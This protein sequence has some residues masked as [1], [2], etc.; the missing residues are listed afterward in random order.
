[1]GRW[2][3]RPVLFVT[4]VDAS[5]EFYRRM[6]FV[7]AWKFA[8]EGSPAAPPTGRAEG[9]SIVA[10][11]SLND[12]E[13]VFSRQRP[14]R[15]GKGMLFI[16]LVADDWKALPAALE[17]GGVPFRE[18]WWGYRSLIVTDPDGNELYFPDPSDPGVAL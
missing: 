1:M 18:G 15:V 2:Y 3:T 12:C 17:A 7:E 11:T 4:D 6:G 8:Q 5:L 10:Q 16:E 14:D 9:A 13:I